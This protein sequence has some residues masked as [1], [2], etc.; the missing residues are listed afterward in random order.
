MQLQ[1]D[2]ANSCC[3]IF[4]VR[5]SLHIPIFEEGM[6]L[7]RWLRSYHSNGMFD[8]AGCSTNNHASCASG[9]ASDQDC[10]YVSN[11]ITKSKY[12][13]TLASNQKFQKVQ[14]LCQKLA[15]I[16]SLCGMSQFRQKYA[17]IET[18]VWNSH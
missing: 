17:Q 18:L 11:L 7:K 14:T 3:H 10:V 6:V 12:S 16:A 13:R 8:Q 4:N 2:M 9:I 5:L 1:E 15:A